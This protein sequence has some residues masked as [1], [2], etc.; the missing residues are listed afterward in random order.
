MS[1]PRIVPKILLCLAGAALL[2]LLAPSLGRAQQVRVEA[3]RTSLTLDEELRLT[4]TAEGDFDELVP[5]PVPDF[6]VVSQGQSSQ[7]SIIGARAQRSTVY[8]WA[9]TPHKAG[10][11]TIGPAQLLARGRVVATS[12][13]LVI[14]VVGV[15]QP[16]ISQAEATNLEARAGEPLFLY[17]QLSHRT[18]YVGQPIVLRLLLY[19]RGDVRVHDYGLRA[20]PE[21]PGFSVEDL[22]GG[23]DRRPRR[24]RVGERQFHVVELDRRLV[25]PLQPGNVR[26]GQAVAEA[27]V[28][29]FPRTQRY[30]VRSQP[31]D[32]EVLPVPSAGRP[33]AFQDGNLGTFALTVDAQPRSVAAGERIVLTLKVTGRGSVEAVKPPRLPAIADAEVDVLPAQDADQIAKTAAGIEGTRV[34]QYVLTPTKPGSLAIPPIEF[35]Y[36]DP[37][38]AAFQ[39]VRTEPLTITVKPAVEPQPVLRPGGA[40]LDLELRDIRGE[41]DLQSHRPRALLAEPLFYAAL[42]LPALLLL[43][44]ELGA[45]VRRRRLRNR[46]ALRARRALAAALHS[47]KQLEARL[48]HGAP[49]AQTL[50]AG[51]QQTLTRFFDDRFGLTLTGQT[52][53]E[54]RGA[55]HALGASDTLAEAVL[56]EIDQYDFGRFAPTSVRDDEARQSAGRTRRLLQ[57]LNRLP[58]PARPAGERP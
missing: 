24:E 36:F 11:L 20:A 34:F 38:E 54:L 42:G 32:L 45:F 8:E 30:P 25:T 40:P 31:F 10:E 52:R 29:N 1:T 16:P 5:P 2:L 3:D 14:K 39:V 19:V 43:G 55:L 46:D 53:S 7:I 48:A 58:G 47:L 26:V 13:P 41:S 21:L 6:D 9:L 49:S 33:E 56:Q 23:G 27:I 44:V 18:V 4:V 12:K 28:G 37:A 22:S 15:E 57:D 50:Y 51:L 35:A 17:P